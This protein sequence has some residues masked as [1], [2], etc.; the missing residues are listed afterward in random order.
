MEPTAAVSAIAHQIQ[1]SVAPV[2]LLAG[3]GAILNV[4]AN[5]LARVV[6]R[7][8]E[9]AGALGSLDEGQRSLAIT[10]LRFLTRRITAANLAIACCTASALLVCVVVATLFIAAPTQLAAGRLISG[11]FIAAMAMLIVGLVLFLHE[12]Q[13]AMRSLRIRFLRSGG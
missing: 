12:V 13:L 10:E 7:A 8:R 3:V 11:L 1:L 2:F 9:I 4:L 6:D 5:R